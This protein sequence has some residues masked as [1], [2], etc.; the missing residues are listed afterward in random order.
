MWSEFCILLL[1][2]GFNRLNQLVKNGRAD[3]TSQKVKVICG[4]SKL[5]IDV[6]GSAIW[7]VG[8]VECWELQRQRLIYRNTPSLQY[9]STPVGLV[10]IS[11]VPLLP[12]NRLPEL[13]EKL[14][15]DV[16]TV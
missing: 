13:I 15:A 4:E 11:P 10:Q 3:V 2:E 1:D 8:V 12:V 16:L 6:R 14:R 5:F 9:S 7:S